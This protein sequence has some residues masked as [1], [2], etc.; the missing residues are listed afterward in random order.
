[1]LVRSVLP[2][3]ALVALHSAEAR[4]T[5]IE[6]TSVESPTFEGRSFGAV[7]TYDKLRGRAHGELDPADPRNAVITDLQLAP[8]NA[9][10]KVEYA[11][12]VY[13]LRPTDA[14][15][16]NRKLFME[17]NNRGLKLFGSLNQSAGGNDPKTAAHA[18]RGFLYE[19][20]YALAWN[21]WDVS[22]SAGGDNLTITL[23]VARTPQG[24]PITGPSY[25]YLVFDNATTTAARLAW[26]AAATDR[27][28]AVL[29]VRDRLTD[30]PQRVAADGWE[31]ADDRSIRLLPAGT[32]FRQ[33]AIYEFAYTAR[34]PAVSGIGFAAT[35]DFVAFLRHAKAD[36]AG[37]A[38]P[39]AGRVDRT[40]AYTVS[41]PG[42]YMNDFVWLGF[43]EDESG[44][45]VFDGVQNWIAAGTGVGLNLRFAQPARTE[46]NRQ[47]HLSPEALFPFA[48]PTL[49]DPFTKQRDG[50]NGRCSQTKTCPK[51]MMVNSA[52]EYWV[53]AGSMLHTDLEGK[54]IADADNVRSY[55]LAGVEHTGSGSPA[56][57]PGVCAQP[58]NTT[59]PSPA[60]RALF[61][62][63]DQWLDGRAPPP[64]AVPRVG[65][66]NAVAIRPTKLASQGLGE[67]PQA[68]LGWPDIP[69]VQYT[70]L[71]TLRTLLDY[72]PAVQ[73]GYLLTNPPRYL[74]KN[75]AA[76]VSKVDADGNEV[77]GVRLPPIAAPVA[78]NT[79]WALRAAA[80]GGPDGCEQFGQTIPFAKTKA[81]RE[82]ARDPRLSIEER[83]ADADAYVDAVTRAARDLEKQRLL[84]PADAQGYIDAARASGIGKR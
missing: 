59:D 21:G 58:R 28:R 30:A 61:V 81:Q 13:L 83:Y 38:N 52:N 39:L 40:L 9:R 16:G 11:M 14:A 37:T 4:I 5:R 17:V 69:G 7:G 67:V 50:R 31:F 71:A 62:A 41:Q 70:G 75:Y 80:F 73:R 33:S 43:N 27:E 6:I 26:P 36:D 29:T 76:F 19:Q 56:H 77:A 23:P 24:G 47:H 84:L 34:D 42:R 25:E 51:I 72:G 1:M 32:A 48:Y 18:G 63:L 15:K 22:A 57:S 10:G 64:S 46:R 8:R 66:G 60:L 65:D 3:L 53:K 68:A 49:D 20:G 55:L 2:L 54:D 82:A 44:R 45:P 74:G 35:R 78:T 79:G 12:D